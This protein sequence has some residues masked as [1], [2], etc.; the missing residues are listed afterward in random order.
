MSVAAT[1][2]AVKGAKGVEADTV[3]KSRKPWT[4][5]TVINIT[6]AAFLGWTFFYAVLGSVIRIGVDPQSV[7]CLPWM[8]Y[9][10]R[11]SAP[12]HIERSK[13]YQYI[14]SGIPLIPDNTKVVKI[15][16]AVAGDHVHVDANGI[17]IND[18]PWGPLNDE[19]LGKSHLT[20]QSVTK[21]YIVQAGDVLML[22]TLPHSYDGRYFGPIPD[23]QIVARAYPIW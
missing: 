22:G 6:C 13:T 18:V 2:I 1:I 14:A 10:V 8:V 16:G 17:S 4:V 23:K 7:R 12:D 15:T 9:L 21:D 3:K 11:T 5:W 20:A 19:V